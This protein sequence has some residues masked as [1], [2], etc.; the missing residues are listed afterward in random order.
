MGGSRTYLTWRTEY[1]GSVENDVKQY[2]Y[3]GDTEDDMCRVKLKD[4]YGNSFDT[5]GGRCPEG[6]AQY[7][8]RDNQNR[9]WAWLCHYHLAT[10]QDEDDEYA[11][12]SDRCTCARG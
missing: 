10:K 2:A 7:L 1:D 3:Q 8:G 11:T 6:C 9:Y 12:V 4:Q 5:Y